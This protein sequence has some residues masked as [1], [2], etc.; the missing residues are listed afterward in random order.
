MLTNSQHRYGLITRCLHWL[1]AVTIIA[2]IILA[3]AMKNIKSPIV[4]DLYSVHKSLGLTL[5]LLGTLFVVWRFFNKRPSLPKA[6]PLWQRYAANG[7]QFCLYCLILIIPLSGWFMSTAAGY[8]P[9]FWGWFTMAAPIAHN[10][11]V[12]SFFGSVHEVC[13]WVMGV[14]IVIHILAALKHALINRDGVLKQIL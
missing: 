13:A 7:V 2:Q 14:L 10:K 3:I 6:I 8:A 12:A 1:I 11:A 4:R 9:S 5:L